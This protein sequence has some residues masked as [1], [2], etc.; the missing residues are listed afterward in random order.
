MDMT[1]A[2]LTILGL[3]V[4]QPR[5]GYD[6]ERVIE[7]RGIRAWTELGFSSIYYLL[8]KLEEKRFV[9]AAAEP[10]AKG[11]RIYTPTPAGRQAAIDAT[12]AALREVTP[13][14]PPILTG[15]ANLPLL[16]DQ[17]RAA[18]LAERR[19]LL[20]ERIHAVEAARLAQQPLPAI[21]ELIFSYAL[22]L[23]QAERQWLETVSQGRPHDAQG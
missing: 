22:S 23:M 20:T 3:L 15:L 9:T 2:E 16:T 10:V 8:R 7:D 1:P 13:L 11:R 19:H 5:H 14:H 4:E 12:L 6:L 17:Q 21:A 18:A